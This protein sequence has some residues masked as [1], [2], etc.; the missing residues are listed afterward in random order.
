ML[1]TSMILH[2]WKILASGRFM[3]SAK[4]NWCFASDEVGFWFAF[5]AGEETFEYLFSRY[6]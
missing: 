1:Q 4:Q 2:C 5:G 3:S 6:H